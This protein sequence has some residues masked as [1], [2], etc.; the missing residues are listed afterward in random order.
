MPEKPAANG[1]FQII[2]NSQIIKTP[3]AQ[4]SHHLMQDSTFLSGIQF[5]FR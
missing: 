5:W 2:D 1:A 4:F 3:V